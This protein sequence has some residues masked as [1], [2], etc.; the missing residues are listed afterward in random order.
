MDPATMAGI[1]VLGGLV[2]LYNSEKARG[3]EKSRLDALEQ[4]FNAAKPPNYN[5]KIE[6]PPAMH[7]ELMNSPK[8]LNGPNPP[9]FN[10][11]GITPQ[12]LQMVGQYN[13]KVGELVKEAQSTTIQNSGD[14]NTA[15]Q[16][17]L[18][19]L[20]RYK[21][22]GDGGFDPQYQEAVQNAGRTAQA[23]AQSRQQSI[24]QDQQRR[25]M[26]GGSGLAEAANLSGA[27]NAMNTNA[28]TNLSAATQSYMNRL[29]ALS[30]GANLGTT[31]Y[32]QDVNTQGRNADIINSYNQRA[33]QNAQ[34]YQNNAANMQNSG[35]LANLNAAQTIA[36][37]NVD[38]SN[39]ALYANQNRADNLSKFT[40]GAGVDQAN[41]ANQNAQKEY[42]NNLGERNYQNGIQD[43]LAKWRQANV[44]Q[45]NATMD[46]QYNNQLG[47]V[48]G[49]ASIDS[50]QNAH[51]I[52]QAQDR[53]NAIQGFTNVGMNYGA[54][55]NDASQLKG[56]Q[57]ASANRAYF[58]RNGSWMSPSQINDY[59]TSSGYGS[60]PSSGYNS[61]GGGNSNSNIFDYRDKNNQNGEYYA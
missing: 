10:L 58:N 24:L 54:A 7:Q 45:Q 44:A 29:N 17:Q 56:S 46:R 4:Q 5:L 59:R 9:Q 49:Q 34:G 40:Y 39:S 25:G 26:A 53:N 61:T 11:N 21:Q 6:D 33:Q 48:Q 18:N 35:Q 30:S 37:R 51:T 14:M 60:P 50:M 2:Q 22:I 19:A 57:E 36:N 20:Q 23:Q 12:T 31:I 43:Y 15:R 42:M 13:P 3:A 47:R 52:G 55:Q 16:A 28:Q 38:N 8:F 27:A 32:N 1:A 41:T